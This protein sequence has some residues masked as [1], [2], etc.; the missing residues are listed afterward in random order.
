[1]SAGIRDSEWMAVAGRTKK[2]YLVLHHEIM[3]VPGNYRA[4]EMIFYTASSLSHSLKLIK[5]SHVDRWSWWEIQVHDMNSTSWPEH[6]GFFGRR[7]G[8][9]ARPSFEKYVAI[10]EKERRM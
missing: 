5:E 3:G 8:R 10:F 1:M 2:I 9:I 6:V 4:D 7:G